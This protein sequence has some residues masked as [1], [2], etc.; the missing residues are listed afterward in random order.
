MKSCPKLPQSNGHSIWELL[1]WFGAINISWRDIV[2]I[3]SINLDF[4][5]LFTSNH[6]LLICY[7]V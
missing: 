3:L 6:L 4:C 7:L 5:R 1:G 2:E